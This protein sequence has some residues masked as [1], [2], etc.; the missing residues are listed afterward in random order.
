[1]LM[2]LGKT[3]ILILEPESKYHEDRYLNFMKGFADITFD[4][5][6]DGINYLISLSMVNE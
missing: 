4:N 3:C 6:N 5:L 1:M 2:D